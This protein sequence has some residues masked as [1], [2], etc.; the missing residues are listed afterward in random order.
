[1]QRYLLLI[2]LSIPFWSFAQ[3]QVVETQVDSLYREDQFY[4]GANY[5][6]LFNKPEGV[7]QRNLSYGLQVGFIRDI[8]LNKSRNIG[9]GI[10]LG[11]SW[12]TYYTN[13]LA[14]RTDQGIT[15]SI[16]EGGSF[17]RNR[18]GN[19]LVQVPIEF[20][21]RT[22][23]S[24]DYKFWRIYTGINVGYVFA[25]S[26]KFVSDSEKVRFDNDDIRNFQYGLSFNFGY[27]TWNIHL[28]YALNPL[29]N[30]GVVTD[31]GE[32]IKMKP[33]QLGLVFYI[34]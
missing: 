29:L 24:T 8:P 1:M 12:D 6:F 33:L 7:T 11:Y 13:L 5:N 18:I 31:D 9:L 23:T 27:G 32:S 34:L 4:I 30:N 25:S 3:T 20:R 17:K 2:F 19:H 21:W 26:S 15:Y 28:Y 22:S 10:G 16:M 14:T